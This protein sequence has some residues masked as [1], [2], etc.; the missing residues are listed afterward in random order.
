MKRTLSIL[1]AM[2]MLFAALPLTAGAVIA[3]GDSPVA[4]PQNE[5]TDLADTGA[6]LYNLWVGSTQVD[7]LNKDDILKD[8]GKAK[9]DPETH[10]LTLKNPTITGEY[11]DC[12]IF[13]NGF[14]LTVKGSYTMTAAQSG[15]A[16][17]VSGYGLTLDGNFTFLAYSE[18]VEASDDINIV[19][20]NVVAKVED[21][22]YSQYGALVSDCGN[23]IFG[24]K[25]EYFEAEV[26]DTASTLCAIGY[27]VEGTVTLSSKLKLSEPEGGQFREGMCVYYVAAKQR[28][29]KKIVIEPATPSDIKYDVWVGTTQVT[30]AN[31]NDILSDGG[32]AKYDPASKTLTLNNPTIPTNTDS[33]SNHFKIS[34]SEDLTVKGS[35]AMTSFDAD[36]GIY[37]A[38]HL[39]LDGDFTFCGKLCGVYALYDINIAS[40]SLVGKASSATA[41]R[42]GGIYSNSGMIIIAAAVTRVEAEG[43]KIYAIYA[44]RGLTIPSGLAVITPKNAVVTKNSVNEHLTGGDFT[45][46]HVVIGDPFEEPE[47][48]IE[49]QPDE[50]GEYGVVL[51][52]IAVTT[53]NKDDIL[54]DGGKAKFDPATSTLTLNDPVLK[55]Y[56]GTGYSSQI[57]SNIPLTIKGSY[58]MPADS[59]YPYGFR[60][61]KLTLDGDFTFRGATYFGINAQFG[62]IT[63]KSGSVKAV[64]KDCGIKANYGSIVIKNGVTRV[65]A[66][67]ENYAIFS[68]DL[69]ALVIGKNMHIEYPNL[70]E[71]SPNLRFVVDASGAA[72]KRVIISSG[73][74]AAGEE[75]YYLWLGGTR[76]TAA[77]KDDIL[78]DG[79]SAKFDPATGTLTLNDP[80]IPGV[81]TF[82]GNIY[83][84]YASI[85]LTVKGSYHMTDN[86]PDYGIRVDQRSLTLEGNFT[87]SGQRYGVVDLSKELYINSGT[88]KATGGTRGILTGGDITIA[89]SVT[90]VEAQGQSEAIY[91]YL[92]DLI[93]GDGLVVKEPAYATIKNGTVLDYQNVAAKYVLIEPGTSEP[94]VEVTLYDLWVGDK[95]AASVNLDDILGDGG[96]AKFDPETGT[97]TLNNPVIAEEPAKRS[98]IYA[99]G[100]DLTVTGSCQLTIDRFRECVYVEGGSLT[101]GGDFKF[102]NYYEGQ[103]TVGSNKDITVRS[104]NIYV[105]SNSAPALFAYYGKITIGSGVTRLEARN[106]PVEGAAYRVAIVAAS[107]DV[108]DALAFTEPEGCYLDVSVWRNATGEVVSHMVLEPKGDE[109]GETVLLGDVDGD[110]KVDIFDASSIQKS[111]AGMGGYP[112]YGT[113]DKNLAEFK[114][115]DV[116]KDGKVDIFDASLIQKFIAGDTSAKAYGIGQPM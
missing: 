10:T 31:K 94:P 16:L 15:N 49:A 104:G 99:E 61:R 44:D 52:R 20:G 65:D 74:P 77:N 26:T 63:I 105:E 106:V 76:V 18:A 116:D 24:D 71:L 69:G 98:F 17:W 96:S 103:I 108:S 62:D 37:C 109:P 60:G 36:Y 115:A 68:S 88:L 70:G 64:G 19:G 28:K 1:L 73:A 78:S 51:G 30:S 72:A 40:G 6:A 55:A 29:A 3:K 87:F 111:I 45:A 81:F 35:Y 91:A 53:A 54:G 113:M 57:L 89:N 90:R 84:I 50:E 5:N 8:G 82:S 27:D 46:K 41:S 14:D 22:G 93:L 95:R 32:K 7:G 12:T 11:N 48:P 85:D 102:V 13:C 79:G 66:Q 80:T 23:L 33:Y 59:T 58:H 67:G 83:K 107:Y 9:F 112:N 4:I 97:L 25:V 39:T 114:V 34:A 92:C 100:F 21:G 47:D 75:K 56:D 2:L 110:G 42:T 86:T 38:A 43:N 101:F